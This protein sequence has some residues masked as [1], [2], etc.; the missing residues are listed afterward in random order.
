MTP[1]YDAALSELGLT[2]RQFA[3]LAEAAFA[4]D[5][6][7]ARLARRL[8]VDPT[9]LTRGLKPLAARDLLRLTPDAKDA[10][11]RRVR[12]TPA[13]EELLE[14]AAPRWRAAQAQVALALGDQTAADLTRALDEAAKRLKAFQ[15][16]RQKA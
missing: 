16:V 12:V 5:L 10:R 15:T 6:P 1:L 4:P 9:T 7:V 3:L 13:G 2:L 8:A 14:Q 11:V